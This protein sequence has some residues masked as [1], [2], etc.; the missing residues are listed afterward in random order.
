[1]QSESTTPSEGVDLGSSP[2]GPAISL[3]SLECIVRSKQWTCGDT[4]PARPPG[5]VVQPDSIVDYESADTDSTSVGP[6]IFRS[7]SEFRLRRSNAVDDPEGVEGTGCEPVVS[8]CESH[9]SPFHWGRGRTAEPSHC[10]C[11]NSRGSTG[12]SRHWRRAHA[13]TKTPDRERWS[14]SSRASIGLLS[15]QA[16]FESP[17]DHSSG[18]SSVSRVPALEAGG[19]RGRTGHPDHL[20]SCRLSEGR[21]PLEPQ[22]R[23]RFPARARFHLF[24]ASKH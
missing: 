8:G 6:T 18:C 21:R 5:P 23:V 24:M 15:Q 7:T 14:R 20:C 1:V 17:R 12:R 22:G 13:P 4:G 11:E 19:R 2:G 10:L 3:T 16:G 9:R